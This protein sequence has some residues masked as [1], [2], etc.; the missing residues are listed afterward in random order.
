MISSEILLLLG[1]VYEY[2]SHGVYSVFMY[3]A[4]A[5]PLIFLAAAQVIVKVTGKSIKS[6]VFYKLLCLTA[7]IASLIQGIMVIYG[8]SSSLTN[9]YLIFAAVVTAMLAADVRSDKNKDNI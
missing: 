7:V 1:I 4:F 2:F 5:I 6:N 9:I 3:G 8:T